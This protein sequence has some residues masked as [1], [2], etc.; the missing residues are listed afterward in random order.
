MGNQT[1][2]NFVY[3]RRELRQ[4]MVTTVQRDKSNRFNMKK[5]YFFLFLKFY[6]N[7][8]ILKSFFG[9]SLSM[10]FCSKRKV[11]QKKFYKT[12]WEKLKKKVTLKRLKKSK[13]KVA[14][15]NCLRIRSLP[16]FLSN[17]FFS[18]LVISYCYCLCKRSFSLSTL[19]SSLSS[20]SDEWVR[21]RRKLFK[22]LILKTFCVHE[23]DQQQ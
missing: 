15:R 11:A 20:S 4:T 13:K 16:L 19:S 12:S 21:E 2:F 1:N 22:Y 18:L 3:F 10:C 23:Q 6:H 7:W 8:M 9:E 14:K 5:F 17:L